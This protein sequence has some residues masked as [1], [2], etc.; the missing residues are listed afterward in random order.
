MKKI[1]LLMIALTLAAASCSKPPVNRSGIDTA[2]EGL[3][4]Y[5]Q[6]E[7]I[8]YEKLFYTN[9]VYFN[10]SAH[11]DDTRFPVL[12]KDYAGLKT[13]KLKTQYNGMQKHQQITVHE[14]GCGT[15][16]K[17]ILITAWQK[18]GREWSILFMLKG[19][20]SSTQDF[21]GIYKQ[22]DASINSHSLNDMTSR[23][24][25]PNVSF[26]MGVTN[27]TG[28]HAVKN[29]LSFI[30]NVKDVTSR[31]IPLEQYTLGECDIVIGDALAS[32]TPVKFKFIQVWKTVGPEKRIVAEFGFI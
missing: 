23:F 27:D 24:Y 3:Q 13:L 19:D 31:F 12:R 4:S 8:N 5:I 7:N 18:I 30:E 25:D 17:K 11:R 26:T 29:G 22:Y 28:I 21:S 20:G 2:L 15:A 32:N 10:G 1:L 6:G 14:A 9:A 16:G